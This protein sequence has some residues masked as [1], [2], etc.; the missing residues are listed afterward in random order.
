MKYL[1]SFTREIVY[2]LM[3][4]YNTLQRVDIHMIY[5][6]LLIYLFTKD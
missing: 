1:L 4:G 6:F 5:P 3:N 2:Y